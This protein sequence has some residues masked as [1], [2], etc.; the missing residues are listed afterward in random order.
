MTDSHDNSTDPCSGDC[1]SCAA[2]GQGVHSHTMP[3]C[4]TPGGLEGWPLAGATAATFLLPM[5]CAATGAIVV[6][7]S[8]VMKVGA[9]IASFVIGVIL[10]SAIS[11]WIRGRYEPKPPAGQRSPDC[12]DHSDKETA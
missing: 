7:G 6:Q 5:A 11:N 12:I 9:A 10:A 1:R 4:Q 3:T 8:P 2:G